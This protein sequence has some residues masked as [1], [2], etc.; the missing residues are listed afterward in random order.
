MPAIRKLVLI[1]LSIAATNLAASLVSAANFGP[2]EA[3]FR[4]ISRE[5]VEI[6]TT[7]SA[8]DTVKAASAM[9]E[10]LKI[11]GLPSAD[12]KVL[13]TGPRKGNLV[14][15]LRG[16]GELK[17][18]LLVSHIDV[19]EAKRE[20]WKFD[21]FKM[22][23]TDGYFRGRGTVDNKAM[24]SIFV[25]NLIRYHKEGF[26]PKRDIIL[27]L[28]SDEEIAESPNNGVR[29]LLENKRSL[30]DAQFAINEGGSGRLVKGKRVRLS[31]QRAE[32]IYLSFQFEVKDRGGHSAR[33]RPGNAIYRLADGLLRLSRHQF[34]P[35]LND[36]TSA[37]LLYP[38]RNETPEIQAAVKAMRAG[39]TS[40]KAVAPR[41][42]RPG[43]NSLIRTTCVATLLA[44]GHAENA[45]PQ[46]ARA[47]VNCRLLP[48]ESPDALEATLNRAVADQKIKITRLGTTVESPVSPLSPQIFGAVKKI[49]ADMWPGVP[50]IPTQSSG[51]TDSRWLCRAGIPTYGISGL[52]T[53]RGK[54]G[55]Q[56]LNEQVRVAD[57]F[58]AKTFLYRLIKQLANS[59]FDTGATTEKLRA[60][61]RLPKPL[62]SFLFSTSRSALCGRVCRVHLS[63]ARR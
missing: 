41:T 4:S 32:K 25:T 11:S 55:V 10:R 49:A 51:Y 9:A 62:T 22:Q 19:V 16:S 18:I 40:P 57:G 53:K 33:P 20:D 39:D 63:V 2:D 54:S 15:R 7:D 36:V 23:E 60:L 37:Y 3:L 28:T 31:L 52:F 44:A 45:L 17:P 27:A 59:G 21:P 43:Y 6:N 50:V 61:R 5:L 46:S 48:G 34:P 12:I 58:E 38:T 8:G 56:G 24:A 30:I 14:V 13:T 26:R 1:L 42:A 35:R 47:T 29:W